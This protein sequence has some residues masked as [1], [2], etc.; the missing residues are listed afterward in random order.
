MRRR[1]LLT[2]ALAAPAIASA[3]TAARTLR[4]VPAEGGVAI[5]DPVWTTGWPTLPFALQMFES[6]YAPDSTLAPR[7]QMAA[8]HVTD[9]DNRRWTIRLREGLR[10]HDN[11]PVLARDCAASIRRWMARD[12][13]GRSTLASR[14]DAIETP[15][16]RTIVFRLNRPFPQ[17]PFVLGKPQ[18]NILPIMPARLAAT[19]PNT[20]LTELI[21]SGPF[22]FVA[23]EF[24][25][26]SLAVQARFEAYQPRNE[27]PDALSGGRIAKLDRIEW[28]AIPDPGTAAAALLTGEVDWLEA[29]APDLLPLLRKNRDV[30][31]EPFNPY[32]LLAL[33]RPNHAWG[34]TA[35]PEV[36]AAIMA[37]IDPQEVMQAGMG[38]DPD[39]YTAPAG[40][41]RPGSPAAST[42]G[43]QHLGPKPA[44]EIKALL[45]AA[46][47]SNEPVIL[48]HPADAPAIHAMFQVVAARLREAGLNVDDQ[49]MD[50]AT[51]ATRCLR[52]EGWSLMML[53][54]PGA[55]HSSPMVAQGLRTGRAAS[56]GWPTNPEVESLRDRW[57]DSTDP[58]EQRA[59][60][61]RIQDIALTDVILSPL[62]H[63]VRKSAWRANVAG[64]L[65]APE[66][67]MW[68]VSKA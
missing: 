27:P 24:A 63:H 44:A 13:I 1:T 28:T 29:P 37:A 11:E 52:K 66:P 51:V 16:D 17:L 48:L 22:R 46:N 25:A 53:N 31:T 61:A 2:T 39:S 4:F 8:G 34:A 50:T 49:V 20:Q 26:G 56:P 68:N 18:P 42:A 60:A 65:K 40:V 62:G 7:P 5:L 36:R 47:Y 58:T 21:G 35:S 10:F 3:A 57:I 33:L 67:L 12:S 9:D 43:M 15:D 55:G 41:F 14:L 54:V 23:R 30:V 38:G 19:D 45:Q 32:G 59:L 6:L 64:I